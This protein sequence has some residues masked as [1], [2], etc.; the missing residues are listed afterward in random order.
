MSALR[1]TGKVTGEVGEALAG[2]DFGAAQALGMALVVKYAPREAPD[3]DH[4]RVF[5][6]TGIVLDVDRLVDAIKQPD[7]TR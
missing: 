7:R 4:I 3:P 2:L 6:V 5:G 1:R